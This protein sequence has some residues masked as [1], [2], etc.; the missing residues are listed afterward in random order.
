[1]RV[2]A[3]G[4]CALDLGFNCPPWPGADRLRSWPSGA[5]IVV[6]AKR[7]R[8]TDMQTYKHIHTYIDAYIPT[9]LHLVLRFET[10]RC[11]YIHF[12]STCA[13]QCEPRCGS[14][15]FRFKIT[16]RAPAGPNLR[17]YIWT[18]SCTFTVSR[19][20]G[21]FICAGLE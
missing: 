7:T 8:H 12:H 14:R 1:M 18:W 5:C 2:R 17:T 4:S 13:L 15:P 20:F 16:T 6:L 10:L 3:R 9:Y 11:C 21:V 19:C